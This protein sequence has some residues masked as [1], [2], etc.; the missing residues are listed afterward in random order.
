MR[1]E[2]HLDQN[3][4]L[5]YTNELN[6]KEPQKYLIQDLIYHLD[7]QSLVIVLDTI[8]CSSCHSSENEKVP[9]NKLIPV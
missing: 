4:I 2:L 6:Q 5:A 8:L 7:L 9:R 1:H 3:D